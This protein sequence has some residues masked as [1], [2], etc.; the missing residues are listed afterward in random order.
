VSETAPRPILHGS[1]ISPYVRKASRCSETPSGMTR[2]ESLPS[3]K[4]KELAA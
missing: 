2:W 4:L 3:L 1:N